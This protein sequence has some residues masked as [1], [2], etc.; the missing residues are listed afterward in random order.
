MWIALSVLV[1]VVTFIAAWE[2]SETI[3]VRSAINLTLGT[4]V[5]IYLL[6]PGADSGRLDAEGRAEGD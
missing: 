2:L 5:L 6:W 1:V 4:L 3:D